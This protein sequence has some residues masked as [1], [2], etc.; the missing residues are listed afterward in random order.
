M[1][2][3]GAK[4]SNQPVENRLQATEMWAKQ[5]LFPFTRL[6]WDFKALGSLDLLGLRS[7]FRSSHVG[8]RPRRWF[9][10]GGDPDC[11]E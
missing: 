11:G 10:S 8:V 4:F 1:I 3:L 5:S 9:G 2:D 6:P 7:Q